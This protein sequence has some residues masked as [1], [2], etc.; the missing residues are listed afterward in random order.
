M[1]TIATHLLN[2]FDRT[3]N[4]V[5]TAIAMAL[6][7]VCTQHH[8]DLTH[9]LGQGGTS[10]LTIRGR[11]HT[12][13]GHVGAYIV[14]LHCT[15]TLLQSVRRKLYP[16]SAALGIN[17]TSRYAECCDCSRVVYYLAS[18]SPQLS[19]RVLYTQSPARYQDAWLQSF[20]GHI[21]R[22]RGSESF[23]VSTV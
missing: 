6:C 7:D 21:R 18:R 16:I 5:N 2:N 14:L 19:S 3:I 10:Y 22:L 15:I 1:H 20:E 17:M 8:D 13:R 23:Y 11:I 12:F 4:F 9:P